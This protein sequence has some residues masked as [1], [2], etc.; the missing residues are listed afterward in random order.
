MCYNI[1]TLQVNIFIL[2]RFGIKLGWNKE[3]NL[4]PQFQKVKMYP[5]VLKSVPCYSLSHV[6]ARR[7][8]EDILL[9]NL[10]KFFPNL[11]FFQALW[12]HFSM[13]PKILGR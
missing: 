7:M 6:R 12:K 13:L 8:V 5:H 11:P 10:N 2:F 1:L 9:G 4:T 3:V